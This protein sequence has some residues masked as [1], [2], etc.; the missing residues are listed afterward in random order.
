MFFHPKNGEDKNRSLERTKRQNNYTINHQIGKLILKSSQ[1]H[2]TLEMATFLK[3]WANPGLFLSIFVLFTFQFKWQI[4]NLYNINWKKHS[5]CAWDL[6]PGWQD[7]RRRRIHWAMA[8]PQKWQ[9]V[10][11]LNERVRDW[12]LCDQNTVRID[13][14]RVT[15]KYAQLGHDAE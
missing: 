9:L 14:L 2:Q 1:W 6:N 10:I 7:G 8:A 3:K 15:E 12:F 11:R 4:Y 5:W 13:E